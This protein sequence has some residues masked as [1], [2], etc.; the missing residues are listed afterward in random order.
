MPLLRE[1]TCCRAKQKQKH[2]KS[3]QNETH[4]KRLTCTGSVPSVPVE[5]R[6]SCWYN[7][8]NLIGGVTS[9]ISG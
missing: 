5:A 7:R 1:T 9:T 6:G 8:A 3:P 4:M 2:A